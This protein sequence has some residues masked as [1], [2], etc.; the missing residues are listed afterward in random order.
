[1]DKEKK[2]GPL[3]CDLN[4][5]GYRYDACA[6]VS[7]TGLALKELFCCGVGNAVR[8]SSPLALYYMFLPLIVLD[9]DPN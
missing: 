4:T 8:C 5:A 1:M 3:Y 6:R 9:L 2:H 7:T